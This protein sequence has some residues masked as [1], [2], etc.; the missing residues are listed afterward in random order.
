MNNSTKK[1]LEMIFDWDNPTMAT[2][3]TI[4]KNMYWA[5]IGL[6]LLKFFFQIVLTIDGAVRAGGVSKG[7]AWSISKIGSHQIFFRFLHIS[8]DSFSLTTATDRSCS[9][10]CRYILVP[11]TFLLFYTIRRSLAILSMC[12]LNHH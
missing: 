8:F 2:A 4:S 12:I 10:E 6:V 11:S 7:L 5:I 3:R 9:R 1:R